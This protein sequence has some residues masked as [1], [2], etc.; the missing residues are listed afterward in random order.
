MKYK[1]LTIRSAVSAGTE[2]VNKETKIFYVI[3]STIMSV[4]PVQCM[5]V[6]TNNVRNQL[7]QIKNVRKKVVTYVVAESHI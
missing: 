6:T 7:D 5:V 3:I 1:A 4:C 2:S